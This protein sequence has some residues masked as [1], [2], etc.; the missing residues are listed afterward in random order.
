MKTIATLLTLGVVAAVLAVAAPAHAASGVVSGKLEL[1][2]RNGGFCPTTRNC[3]GANYPASQSNSY[4]P[5]ANAI[6]YLYMTSGTSQ[7]LIASGTT[8]ATG[9]FKLSWSTTLALGQTR[10]VFK[11]YHAQGRFTTF[12]SAGATYQWNGALFTLING[13]TSTSPQVI[14]ST[15]F[16]SATLP[17]PALNFWAAAETT[18]WY[19]M[20]G[21]NK[22]FNDFT[23]IALKGVYSGDCGTCG[24]GPGKYMRLDA[25]YDYNLPTVSHELGH[26]AS[27]LLNPRST[28]GDYCYG[29]G[30][31]CTPANPY[32]CNGGGGIGSH[33]QDSA[34]WQHVGFEEGFASAV[35]TITLNQ[36]FA[37][38]PYFCVAIEAAECPT[39][40]AKYRM[41]PSVNAGA[42]CSMT[43][44]R[45]ENNVTRYLWDMYD[46]VAD[47]SWDNVS[48]LYWHIYEVMTR[49]PAGYGLR[50]N[51]DPLD[52]STH[53]TFDNRDGFNGQAFQQKSV[54]ATGFPAQS[55]DV[56]NIYD[57]N[58]GVDYFGFDP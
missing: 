25:Q 49:F 36:Q 12:N 28:T 46:G 4:Q 15:R 18:W 32:C 9:T 45:Q 57:R 53:A 23:N 47:A 54:G 37:P 22:L 48:V 33:A 38:D 56:M 29:S 8:T 50:Q 20:M 2:E 21:S 24:S 5:I 27:Y 11:G 16:G 55:I 42:V 26:V 3:T 19:G 7:V 30:Q 58:C 10:V 39:G 14:A 31:L 44:R 17:D 35:A 41:E 34:E 40:T 6:V 13:T 51:N 43:E 52:S 1:W